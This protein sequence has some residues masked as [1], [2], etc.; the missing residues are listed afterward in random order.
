M[1][2]SLVTEATSRLPVLHAARNA[3][4][5]PLCA[6]RASH[7]ARRP[8]ASQTLFQESRAEPSSRVIV[9]FGHHLR[10]GN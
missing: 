10:G 1:A 9:H 3:T 7:L 6:A 8:K 4:R 2:M 5:K